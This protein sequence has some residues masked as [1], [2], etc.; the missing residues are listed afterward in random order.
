MGSK[1][2]N[3]REEFGHYEI[4][5][6]WSVRPSTY[7]LLTI[8]ERKTRYLYAS[9]LNTRKSNVV[10][11]EIINIM[12][13]LLPKS[14][15]M[16]RGKEF[17]L[18]KQIEDELN[19]SIYFSDLGC[20]YQR[21]SIEN[22]NG[23]LRQYYPKGT[24]FANITQKSLDEAVKQINARPR[25]IFNYKSSEEMLKYHVSTQ[26]FEPILNDCVRHEPVN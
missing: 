13:P 24:D 26:N 8:I 18:F 2:I 12:K 7:C 16:D 4:D 10:C 22:A 11:N 20:P 19:C 1:S 21:G 6:V 23:L 3:N 5:T 17:A 15:T 9:R 25:M 14:I